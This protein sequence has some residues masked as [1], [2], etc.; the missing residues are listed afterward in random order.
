M[1]HREYIKDK[2]NIDL[3]FLPKKGLL[4]DE[5]C[6]ACNIG[7]RYS[8]LIDSAHVYG[9]ALMNEGDDHKYNTVYLCRDCHKIS[10][11]TSNSE[12]FFYWMSQQRDFLKKTVEDLEGILSLHYSPESFNEAWNKARNKKLMF[13]YKG[14]DSFFIVEYMDE[15]KRSSFNGFKVINGVGNKPSSRTAFIYTMLLHFLD[16]ESDQWVRS[17]EDE[18]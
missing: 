12:F 11:D 18:K 8:S 7:K 10:P 17:K 15:L 16:N 5:H 6:W 14:Y 2:Y 3:P 4:G 9:R 1:T 13:E